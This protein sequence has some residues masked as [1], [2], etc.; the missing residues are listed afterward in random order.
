MDDKIYFWMG[1]N[2]IFELEYPFDTDSF[3]I[4][5]IWNELSGLMMSERI[6]VIQRSYSGEGRASS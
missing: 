5:R 2:D 6:A 4:W 1:W 3:M